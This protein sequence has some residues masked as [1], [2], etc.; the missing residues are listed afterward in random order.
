MEDKE[1]RVVVGII[2]GVLLLILCLIIFFVVKKYTKK[3][4]KH[5]DT[6]NLNLTSIICSKD[7][8]NETEKYDDHTEYT[9]TYNDNNLYEFKIYYKY[10][11]QYTHE[12]KLKV[13][14]KSLCNSEVQIYSEGITSSYNGINGGGE[15]T[16]TYDLRN[17]TIGDYVNNKYMKSNLYQDKKDL[18]EYLKNKNFKCV[19]Q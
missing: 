9:I 4:N 8:F 2:V 16:L 6:E 12:D 7:E 5:T 10:T 17:N 18:M 15:A 14:L 11:T 1:V 19:Y 3:S 13:I